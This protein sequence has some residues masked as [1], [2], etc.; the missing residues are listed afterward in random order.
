MGRYE[1]CGYP[2][3]VLSGSALIIVGSVVTETLRQI[4]AQLAMR[5]Y[6]RYVR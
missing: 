6:D 1:T 4:E 3:L 5:N 2:A